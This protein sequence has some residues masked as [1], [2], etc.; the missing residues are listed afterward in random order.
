MYRP[1]IHLFGN[2]EATITTPASLIQFYVYP[3]GLQQHLR[4]VQPSAQFTKEL[5]TEG[6]MRSKNIVAHETY[7]NL[8]ILSS[9]R[10]DEHSTKETFKKCF[11]KWPSSSGAE[12]NIFAKTEKEAAK[13]VAFYLHHKG[14]IHEIQEREKGTEIIVKSQD[15]EINFM[16]WKAETKFY[17]EACWSRMVSIRLL[18][19]Y[20]AS[21]SLYTTVLKFYIIFLSLLFS[22]LIRI[23]L[24]RKAWPCVLV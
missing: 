17:L 21:L 5:L 13:L 9:K 4:L 3:E 24:A 23:R 1:I 20:S 22:R 15:L 18:Y 10:E 11:V 6:E 8:L 14:E 7:T 19:V 12:C 16:V 2:N